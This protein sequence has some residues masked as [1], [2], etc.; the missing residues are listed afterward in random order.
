MTYFECNKQPRLSDEKRLRRFK[1]LFMTN[2]ALAP[3]MC[4]ARFLAL[5]RQMP[6][7][8]T[9]AVALFTFDR[10]LIS[11]I[12]DN[13]PRNARKI[14]E[15]ILKIAKLLFC[16]SRCYFFYFGQALSEQASAFFILLKIA[17]KREFSPIQCVFTCKHF[18]T[19][20]IIFRGLRFLRLL[21]RFCQVQ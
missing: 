16:V 18:L 15:R 12:F 9:G 17:R 8:N 21:F 11:V 3:K 4:K 14:V 13:F 7:K 5:E 2:Y 20:F 6:V 10:L 1:F 19:L